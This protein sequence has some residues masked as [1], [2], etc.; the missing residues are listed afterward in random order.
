MLFIWQPLKTFAKE[1]SPF[2][3]L[4]GDQGFEPQFP[5]PERGVLPLHQSPPELVF[6][7]SSGRYCIMP[8]K[9]GQVLFAARRPASVIF[10]IQE[11]QQTFGDCLQA[12]EIK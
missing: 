9:R 8:A 11:D 10:H 6:T 2:G 5:R 12:K 4:A 1:K 3:D 7:W